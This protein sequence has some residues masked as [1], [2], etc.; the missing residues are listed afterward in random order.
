M[1]QWGAVQHS[2]E[3][4]EGAV[5][6]LLV[7]STLFFFILN[8]K[9]WCPLKPVFLFLTSLI[10][11]KTMVVDIHA[12]AYHNNSK[13]SCFPLSEGEVMGVLFDTQEVNLK[14]EPA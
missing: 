1:F 12:R 10:Q 5:G 7:Y 11:F 6:H 4:R 3:E 2:R 9:L 8:P 13:K 14:P